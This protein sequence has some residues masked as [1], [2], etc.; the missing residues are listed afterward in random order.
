[1]QIGIPTGL[2]AGIAVG[3]FLSP[4]SVP[5]QGAGGVSGQMTLTASALGIRAGYAS[6]SFFRFLDNI[7]ATAFPQGSSAGTAQPTAEAK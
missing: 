1:M 4:S 2:V 5:L 3:L 6:Y 7:I